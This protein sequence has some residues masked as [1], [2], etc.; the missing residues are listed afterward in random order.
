MSIQNPEA[1]QSPARPTARR[2]LRIRFGLTV[3]LLAAWLSALA[4][5]TPAQAGA[6]SPWVNNEHLQIR[7]VAGQSAVGSGRSVLLGIQIRL[8]PGWS[9]YWR[10]PGD[11]GLA[12]VL[13]WDGSRNAASIEVDWPA[14]QRKVVLGAQNFVYAE[15]V[16]LPVHVLPADPRKPLLAD[17]MLDYGVCREVC[18]P[19]ADR[20]TI[21][22]PPGEA[23]R[24]ED[25][26]LIDWFADLVPAPAS[27]PD[28]HVAEAGLDAEGGTLWLRLRSTRP[29]VDPDLFLE[30]PAEFWFGPPQVDIGPDGL[31]AEVRFQAGPDATLAELAGKP[32]RVTIV[33]MNV[34]VEDRVSVAA[35][36][37]R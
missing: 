15:E 36:P 33:D 31:A 30:G 29:M 3:W 9:F 26:A 6:A 11:N 8:E 16:V 19:Y 7:L 12:P 5:T 37:R 10:H 27:P 1:V 24:T 4:G 23:G 20:L 28:L 35:A 32:L 13:D 22:L 21:E 25:A 34:A 18:V 14:P 17:L 2:T